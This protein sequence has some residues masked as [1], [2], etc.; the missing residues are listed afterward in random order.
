MNEVL[1]LM[2]NELAL[3]AI[4]FFLL[5]VKISGGMANRK[6]LPVIHFLLLLNFA[7]GFFFNKEGN[8]FGDMFYTTPLIALQKHFKPWRLSYFTAFLRLDETNPAP[9]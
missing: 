6:L 7:L 9:S 8:L 2:K 4:I 1:V 5:I 3:T